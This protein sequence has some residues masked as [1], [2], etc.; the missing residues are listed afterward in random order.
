MLQYINFLGKT[1][2]IRKLFNISSVKDN[3]NT[4]DVSCYSNHNK[5]TKEFN[6]FNNDA[7]MCDTPGLSVKNELFN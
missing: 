6:I 4:G 3:D 5:T 1:L 7:V 2:L